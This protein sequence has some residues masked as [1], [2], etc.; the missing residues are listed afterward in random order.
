MTCATFE[1]IRKNALVA[2][3]RGVPA[4]DMVA[5]AEAL[6]EGGVSMM[7]ITFDQTSKE[8]IR[9]TL[10]S[11]SVL[12]ERMYERMALGAG[13]VLSPQQVSDAHA[14]G[15]TFV[16]SPNTDVAVIE[17]TKKLNMLSMP[18]ALTPSEIALAFSAGGDVVKLFPAGLWGAEYLKAVRAPLAHIPLAV[19]GG[20]TPE[21]IGT[22]LKAGAVGAG[23]GGNL[24]S[25]KTVNEKNFAAISLAAKQFCAAVAAARS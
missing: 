15:A 25:A 16:I 10:N 24:V 2:I 12:R 23:I 6:L 21:N 17:K 5:V 20:V 19:V 11:I 7:E 13:T 14:C 9:E 3:I 1:K 4:K 18:G 8:G 22:F